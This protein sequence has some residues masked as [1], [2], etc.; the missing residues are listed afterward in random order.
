MLYHSKGEKDKGK[1]RCYDA[2]DDDITQNFKIKYRNM[3]ILEWIHIIREMTIRNYKEYGES[4]F[5]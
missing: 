5:R 3:F 4:T 1:Q 2:V